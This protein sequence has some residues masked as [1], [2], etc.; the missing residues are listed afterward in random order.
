MVWVESRF[1]CSIKSSNNFFF[2]DYDGGFSHLSSFVLL[3][4]ATK[5]SCE[6][7]CT[8]T[9]QNDDKKMSTFLAQQFGFVLSLPATATL[10]LKWTFRSLRNSLIC[11]EENK[12]FV[13]F[14]RISSFIDKI[15]NAIKCMYIYRKK[16]QQSTAAEKGPHKHRFWKL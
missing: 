12:T 10:L 7:M 11:V 14:V 4:S 8:R 15:Q 2:F 6:E 1:E 13:F 16:S 3:R 5:K 9:S